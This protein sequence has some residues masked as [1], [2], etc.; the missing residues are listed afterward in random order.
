MRYLSGTVHGPQRSEWESGAVGLLQTPRASYRLDGIAVWALDNGCFT[1]SYPGD[2]RY[3]DYLK[4]WEPHRDRCLFVAAPDVVGDAEATIARS[5]PMIPRIRALGYPVALVLQDGMTEDAVPWDAI[6][7]V[8]V[9]GS[10][11]WKLGPGAAALIDAAR[12]RGVRVHVGRVNSRKRFRLFAALGA[13]TCDGTH[14]AFDPIQGLARVKSW[15]A[16]SEQPRLL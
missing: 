6:N 3:L 5:L 14:M 7:W 1:D 8:F 4:R 12:R 16:E 11:E 9:G 10:T 2:D 13:D 15:V